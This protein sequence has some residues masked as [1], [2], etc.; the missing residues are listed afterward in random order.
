MN[1]GKLEIIKDDSVSLD[2]LVDLRASGV[3]VMRSAHVGNLAPYNMAVAEAGLPVLSVDHTIT[4][5]DRNYFPEVAGTVDSRVTVART[6]KLVCRSVTGS[7]DVY[8]D[9]LQLRSVHT[10]IPQAQVLTSTEYLSANAPVVSEIVLLARKEEP[11]LFDRAAMPDGSV[12]RRDGSADMLDSCG[13]LQLSDDPRAKRTAVLL[14]NAVT[15]LSNFVIETLVSERDVQYHISGPDMVRY[16]GDILPV[17]Q[18][19]YSQLTE[20]ASYR[21]DLPKQL[22]VRLVPGA[23]ARFATT[24]SRQPILDSLIEAYG[25][26]QAET[27]ELAT[28]RR[29]FFASGQAGD[30]N[31]KT[32]FLQSVGRRKSAVEEVLAERIVA[33]PELFVEPRTPRPVTQYDVA[34]EGGLYVPD[35]TRTYSMARLAL[36][37]A[38]LNDIRKR[39][40]L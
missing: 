13:I 14:P 28:E 29:V 18:R 3:S 33:M 11:G 9:E 8:L 38:G 7:G 2:D 17:M 25:A 35:I 6:G 19:L 26:C 37:S 5:V 40:R 22:E 24:R 31:T 21:A 12:L 39:Y 4:G 36:M 23:E 34:A 1:N 16:I 20:T 10:A 15:I 27:A 30:V 32:A